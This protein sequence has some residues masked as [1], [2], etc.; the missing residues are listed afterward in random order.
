MRLMKVEKVEPQGPI[1]VLYGVVENEMIM[2]GQTVTFVS[3]TGH[4]DAG[5]LVAIMP[6]YAGLKEYDQGSP[7]R[8]VKL[9]FRRKTPS[10]PDADIALIEKQP[11]A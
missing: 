1:S 6:N 3:K 10:F 2:T 7:G 5:M 11:S 8:S 9:T 4:R